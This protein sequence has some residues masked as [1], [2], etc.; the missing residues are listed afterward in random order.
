[1]NKPTRVI[2]HCSATPDYPLKHKHFDRFGAAEIKSWHMNDNDWK[3]IGYH[4]V[5]RQN[6]IIEKG[7][8]ET[9]HGAHCR[10]HN[11][12]LGVCWVGSYEP[13]ER[14]VFAYGKLF[15]GIY[16]RHGIIPDDWYGHN[17]FSDKDCPGVSM[18][19]VRALLKKYLE[20]N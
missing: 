19:L 20:L 2:L 15:L 13:N 11:D 3:D 5:I 12:A 1:M 18:V 4:W 8:E 10:G 14:Q 9:E 17:E 6:G 7:R 16:K